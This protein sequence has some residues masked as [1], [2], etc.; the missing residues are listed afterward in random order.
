MRESGA[1]ELLN[2]IVVTEKLGLGSH[3]IDVVNRYAASMKN[4]GS[5]TRGLGRI[6]SRRM[7]GLAFAVLTLC[8][9]PIRV[10]QATTFTVDSTDDG[11]D[12][13][14]GNGKCATS[15]LFPKCTLRAAVMEAN[16]LSGGPH[17]I[18]VP[19]GNY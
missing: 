12:V 8:L 13:N 2:R 19:A 18:I 16:A 3:A 17:T 5:I 15:I 11:P 1:L 14:T 6:L 10:A 7:Y 9:V 4:V